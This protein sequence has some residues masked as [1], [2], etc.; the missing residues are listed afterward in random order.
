M[1]SRSSGGGV[2]LVVQRLKTGYDAAGA[3]A[4]CASGLAAGC[5]PLPF[6]PFLVPG[7]GFVKPAPVP[8]PG[9]AP[10]PTGG[11]VGLGLAI[12]AM[13]TSL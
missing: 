1:S 6:L 5:F 10:L 2:V 12:G 7:L 3:E 4:F 8:W 11:P 9:I 13:F